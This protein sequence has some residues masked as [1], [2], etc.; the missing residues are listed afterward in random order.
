MSPAGNS[1]QER[2]Q[3]A[4]ALTRQGSLQQA[5]ALLSALAAERPQ[6]P[7]PL[8]FLAT[9][10]HQAGD[11]D[12]ALRTL[13]AANSI[14]PSH[15]HVAA[16]RAHILLQFGRYA[17]AEAAAILAL[18]ANAENLRAR[19]DLACS[20]AS[21]QR[22]SDALKHCTKALAQAPG[23]ASLLCLR[24][25]CMLML[26]DVNDALTLMLD[27]AAL[28]EPALVHGI[29]AEFAA[30]GQ[31]EAQ[32][33]LLGALA[34]R[35]PADYGCVLGLA[36]ALHARG[37]AAEA[38]VWAERAQAIRPLSTQP[39][40]MRAISLIDQ[41]DVEQGMAI[42]RD[43]VATGSL[44]ANDEQRFL[45]V[46][47]YDPRL[48]P[49]TALADHLA[50]A[51]RHAAPF[52][53]PFVAPSSGKR[54]LRIGWA[55]PRLCEGPVTRFFSGMFAAFDRSTHEH[56]LIELAAARDEQTERME[57]LADKVVLAHGSN[58]EGLLQQL[59]DLQL[60]VLVD[61]AGH[62]PFGR[63]RVLAQRV[64][65]LQLC[66]LDYFDTTGLPNMDGWISDKWLSPQD[67]PQLFSE[68]L[69]RLPSGRFCYTPPSIAPAPT[70]AGNREPTFVSFNR[71]AK[72][73]H[74]VVEAWSRI[75]TAVPAAR[76]LLGAR[77]LDDSHAASYLRRRFEQR[78]IDSARLELRGHQDYPRLLTAYL[79]AD[80]ALDPFPFSGCTT[81]C[82]ALWM[83]VPV[84]TLPG[85]S[86]VS[87]QTASLLWR[88]D[89]PQW[90]ADT[91]DDYVARAV[92]M[93][94]EVDILRE[95]R[96]ALREAVAQRLCN[97]AQQASEFA[98]LLREQME[99][100]RT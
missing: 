77:A 56:V 5:G 79:Q 90:V 74:E 98:A 54:R 33:T 62:A 94:N 6:D 32:I 17:E 23:S 22:W 75:L 31:A 73:N 26:G 45:V 9:V 52:G 99:Q 19:F 29:A 34:A 64:A 10:Q 58:D 87:R 92:A 27:S 47:H 59:R 37:R 65:P 38:I 55:S 18:R 12:A 48:D 91:I 68:S 30:R 44:N 84:I 24:A 15:E 100:H 72:L 28:A 78:G 41:G 40:Q 96:V 61:L 66:W 25:R 85:W 42:Y 8:V 76:L 70:Y 39:R 49:E 86:V 82:D 57:S 7:L 53:P 43:L 21:Q 35:N 13:D 67:S 60:D 2:L 14:A 20:L 50:W 69:L 51:A 88:L 3:T 93:A 97:T 95:G 80:I 71:T 46:E 1:W 36:A 16:T 63:P 89:R 4:L 81:S 83:G 11:P